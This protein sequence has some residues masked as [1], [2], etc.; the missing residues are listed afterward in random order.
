MEWIEKLVPN[1]IIERLERYIH[2]QF[3]VLVVNAVA[4]IRDWKLRNSGTAWIQQK[5]V[6]VDIRSPR[7]RE[8]EVSV[9]FICHSEVAKRQL[10]HEVQ[11]TQD[12]STRGEHNVMACWLDKQASS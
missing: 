12:S 2:C 11:I 6:Y 10:C 8:L 5:I 4:T 3:E 1:R 7:S 9:D